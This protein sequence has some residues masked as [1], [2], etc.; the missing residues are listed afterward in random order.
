MS[1][2]LLLSSFTSLNWIIIDDFQ[3]NF[4][5]LGAKVNVVR[6]LIHNGRIV[7]RCGAHCAEQKK[8]EETTSRPTPKSKYKKWSNCKQ[9]GIDAQMM[10]VRQTHLAESKVVVNE[11]KV[12][13]PMLLTDVR[14]VTHNEVPL[15]SGA[16]KRKHV[17]TEEDQC[18]QRRNNAGIETGKDVN[19]FIQLSQNGPLVNTL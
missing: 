8:R 4:H 19:L 12:A 6:Q 9:F 2:I 15:W 16:P 17:R 11:Q 10:C 13:P 14:M 7:S 3:S 1:K 18:G 5:S